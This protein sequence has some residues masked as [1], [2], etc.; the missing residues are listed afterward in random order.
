VIAFADERMKGNQPVFVFHD[1]AKPKRALLP[2]TLAID[3]VTNGGRGEEAYEAEVVR[4][5]HR[6]KLTAHWRESPIF[7][8]AGVKPGVR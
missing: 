6:R 2:E 5:I 8:A 1:P 7:D 3:G 4:P